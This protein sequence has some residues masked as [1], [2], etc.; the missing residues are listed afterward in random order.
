MLRRR[1]LI[2]LQARDQGWQVADEAARIMGR[3][4]SW[5]ADRIEHEV[6]AYRAHVE[7]SRAWSRTPAPV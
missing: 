2:F 7:A 3:V 6:E 1:T 4:L 5:D